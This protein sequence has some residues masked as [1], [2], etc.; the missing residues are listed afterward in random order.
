[1]REVI[2]LRRGEI[3]KSLD[4]ARETLSFHSKAEFTLS[5]LKSN[6]IRAGQAE[7]SRARYASAYPE[8]LQR[9][10]RRLDG[11]TIGPAIDL[12]SVLLALGDDAQASEL[13]DASLRIVEEER[14]PLPG[15]HDLAEVRIH[16]LRGDN[17]DALAAL[18]AAID[19][20]WR[21]NWWFFMEHDSSLDA[22]R[23][24]PAFLNHLETLR[25]DMAMQLARVRER[26]AAGEF[27]E[28]PLPD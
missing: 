15:S 24:E 14:S 1:M 18:G 9:D 22:L 28:I 23:S 26:Q 19:Q 10:A 6:D 20:G 3:E 27:P 12:A 21:A 25:T 8:L 17:G 5:N 7:M 13:L 11:S 2:H 16:A 4:V